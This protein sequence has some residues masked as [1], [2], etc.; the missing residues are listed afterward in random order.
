MS[1]GDAEDVTSWDLF[2][3]PR[4]F[5]PPTPPPTEAQHVRK[6]GDVV[7][8]RLVGSHPLWGHYLWNAAP[9]LSMYLEEH[10][11]LVRDKYVLE[12]GAAAGLP[13]IVAM[14]LGARAVVATDYP[15]PDLMQNLSFNL[16]RYGS[17]KAVGYIWGAEGK[18]V[19]EAAT[20]CWHSHTLSFV[21][22]LDTRTRTDLTRPIRYFSTSRPVLF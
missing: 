9:T 15:D 18:R 12:L 20:W 19:C 4:D 16:A 17:A 7:T 22:V 8:M 2:E 3:E 6:N 14:K 11:A 21:R 5:R 1:E 10:D 13:S